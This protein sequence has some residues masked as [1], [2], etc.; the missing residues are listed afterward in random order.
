V[1]AALVA[2]CAVFAGCGF[3]FASWISRLPQVRERLHLDAS[4]LGLV[5]LALS[6]GALIAPPVSGMIVARYGTRRTVT[7]MAALMALALSTIALGHLVGVLPVVV[8]L[9]LMGF[10]QAAWSVAMNVQGAIVERRLARSIMSRFHAFFSI[11]TVA[12]ACVGAAAIA[13]KVPVAAHLVVVAAVVLLVVSLQVRRFLPDQVISQD[14]SMTPTTSPSSP[15]E[16]D[17]A[18][19]SRGPGLAWRESRTL[20]IGVCA[21]AFA[22]AE[23]TGNDWISVATIDGYGLSPSF[24]ALAYAVF[25]TAM[26]LT[27]WFGPLWLDQYGCVPVIRVLAVLGLLGIL[28]FVYAP[29]PVVAYLGVALWG[30]GVALGQPAALSAAAGGDAE[31]DSRLAAARVSVVASVCNCAFLAGPPAIGFLGDRL[32]VLQA[33]VVVTA[34][35]L[36]ALLAS[37]SLRPA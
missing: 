23:G 2:T 10:A 13:L 33:L 28:L 12:G 1:R 27:R 37:R 26:T 34:A 30:V 20:L 19:R 32:G 4:Q 35:L 24:G 3:A 22:F 29:H 7:A 31:T 16:K 17:S 15:P 8:G 21:L 11:G 9:F 25:L 5:L 18:R 6:A 36:L 14:P